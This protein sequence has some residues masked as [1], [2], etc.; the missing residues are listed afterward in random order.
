M[1]RLPRKLMFAVEA[2]VDIAYYS[3]DGLVRSADITERQ[4]IPRRYLEQVLQQL[5]RGGVLSGVRGP[6]GGYRLARERRR[7]TIAD[8]L[9]VVQEMEQ[10]E[11]E[12]LTAGSQIA[13]TVIRPIWADLEK[14]SMDRLDD[15]TVEDI[16]RRAQEAGIDVESK[17]PPADFVI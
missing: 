10:A 12:A 2:V 6:R 1:F 7:T 14:E 11:E 9:R 8:I 3:K 15:L 13:T 16:C 17:P 5:V 4:G